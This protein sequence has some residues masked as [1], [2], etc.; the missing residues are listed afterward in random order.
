MISYEQSQEAKLKLFNY[1]TFMPG[2]LNEKHLKFD[3][4]SNQLRILFK[5]V[6]NIYVFIYDCASLSCG[7]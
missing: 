6:L 7:I 4:Q 1:F 3:I 5:N 2:H